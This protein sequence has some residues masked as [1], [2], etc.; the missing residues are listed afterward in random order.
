MASKPE[1]FEIAAGIGCIFCSFSLP[2]Y[3]KIKTNKYTFIII[4]S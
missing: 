1:I 3:T 4:P 2:G